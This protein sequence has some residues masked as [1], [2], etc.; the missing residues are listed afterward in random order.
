MSAHTYADAIGLLRAFLAGDVEGAARLISNLDP[1]E[2]LLIVGALVQ[3]GASF[4]DE[5]AG[6][7]A[8]PIDALLHQLREDLNRRSR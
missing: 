7:T 4:L 1:K 8:Q 2:V 6:L 5:I 3:L